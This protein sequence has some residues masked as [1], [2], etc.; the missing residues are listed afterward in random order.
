MS[1]RTNA[2][3]FLEVVATAKR[4]GAN[5]IQAS[6][7][8][9]KFGNDRTSRTADEHTNPDSRSDG[10]FSRIAVRKTGRRLW[11]GGSAASTSLMRRSLAEHSYAGAGV[12]P[13]P[14][15][16][17]SNRGRFWKSLWESWDGR[18]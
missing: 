8:N 2:V 6:H 16:V 18:K 4:S 14:A 12:S 7:H 17:P 1:P 9:S 13:A 3:R 15:R 5:P 11:I 10:A